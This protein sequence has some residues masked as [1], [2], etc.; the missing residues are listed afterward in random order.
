MR[1]TPRYGDRPIV[2]VE[3]RVDGVHP[4]SRQRKRL[5]TLLRVL[6][7][8]EWKHTSRCAEWTVQDVVAHLTTTNT[9]WVASIQA[10]V[11]G[12]PT[13]YLGAFDPVAS[14]A[15]LVDQ[16]RGMDAAA[17]LE[18]FAASCAALAEVVDTLGD[19]DWN[20]VAEAP[21]GHLPISLV[22]DHALWDAWVHER[23][24]VVPLGRSPVEDSDE[25]LTCLRYA[26]ALGRAFEVTGGAAEH[27]AVVLDVTKPDARIVIDVD[28]G[29]VRIHDGAAPAGAATCRGDAVEI[30]EML[31]MR[32]AGVP[33]PDPIRSLSAGL[34]VVFDQPA[35]V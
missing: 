1:L 9:F 20:S 23:D 19:A 3:V 16:A 14:P 8:D 13:R 30:L 15:Q 26:A 18:Q 10:G 21:P 27:D 11:A 32:D 34:A 5:E 6:T 12:E 33:I 31:S 17:T 29:V 7:E 25:V 2:S 28:A 22:A 35:P 24:I 4:L